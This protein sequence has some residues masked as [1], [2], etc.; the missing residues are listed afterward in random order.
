MSRAAGNFMFLCDPTKNIACSKTACHMYG[1]PCKHTK[2]MKYAKD[3]SKATLVV[4]CSDEILGKETKHES[5]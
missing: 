2:Y 4:Q 5:K 1:G 3:P